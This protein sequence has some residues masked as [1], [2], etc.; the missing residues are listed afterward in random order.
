M[1][2]PNLPSWKAAQAARTAT[3]AAIGAELMNAF[4]RDKTDPSAMS[5]LGHETSTG[6]EFCIERDGVVYTVTVTRDLDT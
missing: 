1:S 2:E 4:N 6:F 5:E 3:T